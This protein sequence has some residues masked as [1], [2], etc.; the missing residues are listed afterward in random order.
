MKETC[1]KLGVKV[2]AF[3]PIGQGLLTEGLSDEKWASNKA[4]KIMRLKREELTRLRAVVLELA[5]KYKKSMA[6]V[7]LNWCIQHDVIPLVGCRTP[8]QARDSV[9]CLGWSLS[10]EDVKKLDE[11]ALDKSTLDSPFWRRMFFVSLFAIVMVTCRFLDFLGFGS[12]VP[13]K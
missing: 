12:V 7:A 10:I 6:Q 13:I 8:Q 3:S 1:D 5:Q 4:A 11:V 9:G 2:I